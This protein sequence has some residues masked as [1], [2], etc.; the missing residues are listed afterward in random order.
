MCIIVLTVHQAIPIMLGAEIGA[1][2][3][4]AMISLGHSADRDQFRRAFAAATLNDIY[5]FL[6]YFVILPIELSF[7]EREFSAK[8]VELSPIP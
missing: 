1:S 7:G 8:K 5:N 4:N 3:I 6:C 2:F